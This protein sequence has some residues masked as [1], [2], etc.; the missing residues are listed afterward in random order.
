MQAALSASSLRVLP[1]LPQVYAVYLP[2]HS[3]PFIYLSLRLPPHALDVNVHPTKR[4]VH[5]LNQEEIVEALQVWAARSGW[6][7]GSARRRV[8]PGQRV[9]HCTS[10]CALRKLARAASSL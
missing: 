9:I 3:H 8:S 2:K 4:E 10:S 5:F 1:S 7:A 6:S